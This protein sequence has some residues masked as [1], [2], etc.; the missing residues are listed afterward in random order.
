VTTVGAG[1]GAVVTH[2]EWLELSHREAES[3]SILLHS[4]GTRQ[5]RCCTRLLAHCRVPVSN[6][7]HRAEFQIPDESNDERAGFST[8]RDVNLTGFQDLISLIEDAVAN[9]KME[10]E[11]AKEDDKHFICMHAHLIMMAKSMLTWKQTFQALH[12]EINP[13]YFEWATRQAEDMVSAAVTRAMFDIAG[14]PDILKPLFGLNDKGE[15]NQDELFEG[16]NPG[17]YL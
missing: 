16:P 15:I 11:Q 9:L 7:T 1:N 2:L 3:S 10:Y 6:I 14:I 8:T 4:T 12:D 5:C 17:G 13:D